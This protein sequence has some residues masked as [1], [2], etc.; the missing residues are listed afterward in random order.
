M[1]SLQRHKVAGAICAIFALSF[2]ILAGEAA[3]AGGLVARPRKLN[4]GKVLL[5]NNPSALTRQFSL[6]NRNKSET[7]TAVVS[8]ASGAF[9]S[10]PVTVTIPP[11]QSIVFQVSFDPPAQA[12]YLSV[13]SVTPNIGKPFQVVLRGNARGARPGAGPSPTPTPPNMPAPTPTPVP[14]ATP[15]PGPTATP[16]AANA[17]IMVSFLDPPNTGNGQSSFTITIE[18]PAAPDTQVLGIPADAS[19]IGFC[20]VVPIAAPPGATIQ[21]SETGCTSGAVDDSCPALPQSTFSPAPSGSAANKAATPQ[22]SVSDLG[23][24]ELEVELFSVGL[25]ITPSSFP[26]YD[27]DSPADMVGPDGYGLFMV[28]NASGYNMPATIGPYSYTVS[29]CNGGNCPLMVPYYN[30]G[31]G[32][33]AGLGASPPSGNCTVA[34][35]LQ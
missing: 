33:L 32:D 34:E 25:N 2:T 29:G 7:I 22:L 4:F 18:D 19:D 5:S 16:V 27:P 3:A 23:D 11:Q 13:I 31:D 9:G 6:V 10:D 1:A 12:K 14:T 26:G 8:G 20:Y 21:V 17:A 15:T 28:P 35:P 30:T 24:T